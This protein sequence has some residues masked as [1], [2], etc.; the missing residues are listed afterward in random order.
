M[1]KGQRRSN[2]EIRKPKADKAKKS[3]PAPIL[4]G[5]GA[6]V[7]LGSPKKG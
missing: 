1:A 4:L 2:R 7:A 3:D 5:K 6:P